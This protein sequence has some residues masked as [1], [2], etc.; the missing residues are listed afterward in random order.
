[1][2]MLQQVRFFL[3]IYKKE[4]AAYPLFQVSFT[5]D[6][7]TIIAPHIVVIGADE[8]YRDGWRATIVWRE[9]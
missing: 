7:L 3:R 5:G 8:S 2:G 9:V 1:M 4:P 6:N